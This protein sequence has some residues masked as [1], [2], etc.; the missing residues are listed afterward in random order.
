MCSFLC[1]IFEGTDKFWDIIVICLGSTLGSS[2]GI[3]DLRLQELILLW[4]NLLKDI[5]HHIG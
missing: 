5:W 3:S 1:C 2:C 4:T